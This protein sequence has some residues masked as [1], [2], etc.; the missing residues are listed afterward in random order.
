LRLPSRIGTHETHGPQLR[1]HGV[2][3]RSRGVWPLARALPALLSVAGCN[4][5]GYE[6]HAP[7]R[8]AAPAVD[9]SSDVPREAAADVDAMSGLPQEAAVGEAGEPAHDEL[10]A[11]DAGLMPLSADAGIVCTDPKRCNYECPSGSSTCA[12]ECLGSKEC[13][14]KCT[15]GA[16]CSTT[17]QGAE[18]CHIECPSFSSCEVIC[19]G[20]AECQPHCADN[21][22]CHITCI[23]NE[24]KGVACSPKA[25]CT[26][27]CLGTSDCAFMRCDAP[28][29]VGEQRMYCGGQ[30]TCVA[31]P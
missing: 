3:C 28:S 10:D 12:L 1:V 22:I 24:C 19:R 6:S 27:D 15:A 2:A 13:I 8:D 30:H 17:C 11:D 26:L 18:H 21:S 25:D 31:S 23:D 7:A 14:S 20:S 29:C 16:R 9:A 5:I 4:L